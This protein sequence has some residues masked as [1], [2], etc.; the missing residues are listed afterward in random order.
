MVVASVFST[1]APRAQRGNS[2]FLA[3]AQHHGFGTIAKTLTRGHL[4]CQPQSYTEPGS[5]V[6]LS[7]HCGNQLAARKRLHVFTGSRGSAAFCHS[8]VSTFCVQHSSSRT[9]QGLTPHS[10]GAPTAGH[11]AR[12]GGTRY[13]FASPGLASY[14]CRPLNSNVRPHRTSLVCTRRIL[15]LSGHSA[16]Q[17]PAWPKDH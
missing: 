10:S 8:H 1:N 15:R 3:C 4:F 2:V 7:A 14:R 5:H 9:V 17:Q 6:H 11:Q 12:S 16:C 13:I